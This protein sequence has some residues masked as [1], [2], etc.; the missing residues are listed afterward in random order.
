M[1]QVLE[2][3]LAVEDLTGIADKA[4]ESLSQPGVAV[5][6]PRSMVFRI[7]SALE[8]LLTEQLLVLR[9]QGRS[10]TSETLELRIR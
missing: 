4:R 2:M 6:I 7:E 8:G 9:E 1:S 5:E 3:G 10:M